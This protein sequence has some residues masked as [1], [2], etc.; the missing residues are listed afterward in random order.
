MFFLQILFVFVHR[1]IQGAIEVLLGVSRKSYEASV[2]IDAPKD[3]LWQVASARK[4]TFDEFVPIHIEVEP[5]RD[6]DAVHEGQIKFGDKVIPISYRL[7][8]E[9]PG[10][11]A[12][13]Q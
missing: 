13:Y 6:D 9:R 1:S 12:V 7:I 4:I 10:E 11:A 3:L 5:S 2:F 8:S